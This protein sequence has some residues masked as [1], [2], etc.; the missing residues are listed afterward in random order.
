[1]F[2]EAPQLPAAR[3][4]LLLRAG[5]E[6]RRTD[7]EA[8]EG[9]VEPLRGEQRDA[10]A[11]A[12]AQLRVADAR[13]SAG[14]AAKP[15]AAESPV[16]QLMKQK[17]QLELELQ[18][19]RED[20][21][22][23]RGK[24][25]RTTAEQK[26][27]MESLTLNRNKVKELQAERSKLLEEISTLEA[28]LRTQMNETEQFQ[29][30]Y[31]K[32]KSARKS[33]GEQATH[34]TE[35]ITALKEE[36]ERLKAELEATRRERDRA[37]ESV[38]TTAA[39]VEEGSADACLQRLWQKLHAALPDVFIDTHV[40]TEQTFANLC[41]SFVE[42]LRVF[43]TLE[44]HVHHLLRDLRQVSEKSDKLNHFYIMFTKNAGLAETLQDYIKTGKRKSSFVNLLR[45]QQA[46]LRAFATGTY[47]A[48]VRSPVLVGAELNY[49][50]WPLKTSF[51]KSEEAAL[52]EY[53]K[54][55]VQRQLPE[56]VGTILR[57]EA[58]DKAYDDYNQLMQ[59]RR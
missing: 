23:V 9:A 16:E 53:F 38:T 51:T 12:C 24:L 1:M 34:H 6:R 22:E 47:K 33:M 30:Q 48:I 45:S 7:A 43:A 55:N 10:A 31:E 36:V 17:A 3:L 56:Q 2:A 11:N 58:A 26:E 32:L 15:A 14:A 59:A 41:T 27:A 42:F 35:E 44:L 18:R 52:G 46:W 5:A 8:L 29:L 49:K 57:R 37:Q 20:H 28:K 13:G 40:P 21:E 39:E 54:S 25:E 50:Q 4:A 19:N